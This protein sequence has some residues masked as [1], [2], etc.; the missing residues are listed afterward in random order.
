VRRE[1]QN[2]SP[3]SVHHEITEF[4]R[5]ALGFLDELRIW[6]ESLPQELGSLERTG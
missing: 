2:P 5:S 4:G 6:S 3:V 1:V